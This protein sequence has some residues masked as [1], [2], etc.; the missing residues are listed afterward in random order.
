MGASERLGFIIGIIAEILSA[1]LKGLSSLEQDWVS[2]I[3]NKMRE[4]DSR[5]GWHRTSSYG[6]T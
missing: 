4:K 5:I 3:T 6:D 2:Y 1:S